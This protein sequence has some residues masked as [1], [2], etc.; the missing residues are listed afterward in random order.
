MPNHRSPTPPPLP[1]PA[2]GPTARTGAGMAPPGA[3]APP[4]PDPLPL[5]HERDEASGEA[6]RPADPVIRQAQRD[7]DRELVDTDLRATPGLDAERRRALVQDTESDVQPAD[8]P[9]PETPP[10][11]SGT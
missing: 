9:A 8:V 3:A 1:R 6:A 5:P 10:H 7:L 2:S 11:R 4:P